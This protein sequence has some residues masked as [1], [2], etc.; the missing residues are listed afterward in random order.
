MQRDPTDAK[1]NLRY[2]AMC[3]ILYVTCA[4]VTIRRE[5]DGHDHD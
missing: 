4:T 3:G 5:H 2:C 1:R